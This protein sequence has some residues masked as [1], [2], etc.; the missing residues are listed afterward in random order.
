MDRL[1]EAIAECE[2]NL[3]TPEAQLQCAMIL[4]MAGDS[5]ARDDLNSS[6]TMN[7]LPMHF[8]RKPHWVL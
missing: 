8:V 1:D 3:S 5:R 2:L 4:E 7:A 6:L